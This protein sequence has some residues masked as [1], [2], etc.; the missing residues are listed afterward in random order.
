MKINNV[1]TVKT[2]IANLIYVFHFILVLFFVIAP[3]LP[4]SILEKTWWLY[5]LVLILWLLCNQTC[6]LTE[7]ESK[8]RNDKDERRFIEKMLNVIGFYP[9][10][11]NS[12]IIGTIILIG[13]GLI[14]MYRLFYIKK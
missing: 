9:G 4:L 7:I 5:P 13:S 14:V 1:K 2:I 12:D 10:K 3:F 8:L 11:T 6:I